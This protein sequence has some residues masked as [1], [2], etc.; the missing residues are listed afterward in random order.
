MPNRFDSESLQRIWPETLT[1]CE[2]TLTSPA[3]NLAMDDAL[4]AAVEA[5][6]STASLRLWEPLNYFVVLGRSNKVETEVNLDV[7][8]S[9]GIP[10]LRR[11]SGGGTVLVGPG[12]LCYTLSLPLTEL[13]RG[14]GVS[15]VTARL[16]ERTSAGLNGVL[17]DIDVCGTSDLVWR[18]RK[19]SGNAQR[20]LRRAFVHHGTLLYNFDLSLLARCLRQPA[21][22][23]EY[24]HLRGHIDFVTNVPLNSE[25]L[26]CCLKSAWNAKTSLYS[27]ELLDEM[28]RIADSK[29]RS[30]EWNQL[31]ERKT[32]P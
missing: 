32:N 1:T 2:L 29:Y 21:R 23:P 13:H 5:H 31:I 3:E 27:N 16:M 20:W 4:L 24:R 26:R 18:D 14:M 7:C 28:R 25:R 12:C 6:P 30:N 10:I 9:E 19:F 8:E 15:E 11:S 22:Q 17:A